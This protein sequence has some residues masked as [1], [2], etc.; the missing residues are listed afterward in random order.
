MQENMQSSR[1]VINKGNRLSLFQSREFFFL[2]LSKLN[3]VA[4]L[5]L[6]THKT[7]VERQKQPILNL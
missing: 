5:I 3:L 4:H 2:H 1:D 6:I 7:G